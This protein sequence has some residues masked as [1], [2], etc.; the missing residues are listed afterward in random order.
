MR[1]DNA[2]GGRPM[3][4]LLLLLYGLP[5]SFLLVALASATILVLFG[6]FLASVAD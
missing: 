1:E 4:L 2:K 3:G 6:L 5:A